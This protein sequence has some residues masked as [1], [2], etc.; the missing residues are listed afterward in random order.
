MG[1][2]TVV[3]DG[4]FQRLNTATETLAIAIGDTAGAA[5]AANVGPV[6]GAVHRLVTDVLPRFPEDNDTANVYRAEIAFVLG[7]LL[8]PLGY[9]ISEKR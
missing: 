6:L 5:V 1:R 7:S 8:Q 4:N 3:F 2:E 9:E